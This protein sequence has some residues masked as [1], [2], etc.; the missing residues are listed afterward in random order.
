MVNSIWLAMSSS[1]QGGS[2]GGIGMLLPI[3]LIFV[4]MYFLMIR[5]QQK[6]HRQHQQMIQSLRKGDRVVTSG[7][8]YATVLNIKEKENRVVVRIAENVKVEIQR[9]SIAG[10]I[11][12]GE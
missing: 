9:N 4:I 5:P 6:K 10:L 2:G 7:G 11:E 3:I 1:G 12:K 8:L